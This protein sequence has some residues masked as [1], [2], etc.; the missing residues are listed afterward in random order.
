M[1]PSDGR[2]PLT[3]TANGDSTTSDTQIDLASFTPDK[4]YPV[5]SLLVP[6]T[7]DLT[8]VIT[9]GTATPNLYKGV[10][11]T[12]IYVAPTDFI[13]TTHSNVVMYT[14]DNIGSVQPSTYVSR[15]KAY[16]SSFIPTGYKVIAVDVHASQNRDIRVLT[17]ATDSDTTSVQGSGTANTTLTLGTA[18]TSVLGA[19]LIISFE[20]G[21]STDEIYGARITIQAV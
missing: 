8:N 12:T 18:W 5:G 15:S 21:A 2:H 20:F 19:Y 4:D 13:I 11:T 3:L 1:L 16:V 7:Y 10:T 17:G 14:R 9:A 6:L